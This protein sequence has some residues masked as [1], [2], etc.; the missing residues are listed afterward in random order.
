MQLREV[1][2][3]LVYRW[4]PTTA[5]RR[6][7]E[8]RQLAVRA[9]E[10]LPVH[11]RVRASLLALGFVEEFASQITGALMRQ[12]EFWAKHYDTTLTRA[13]H[14]VWNGYTKLFRDP[15][16]GF[17]V[18]M[19]LEST[20]QFKYDDP[21]NSWL[22]ITTMRQRFEP[23]ARSEP[24]YQRD[25]YLTTRCN[26]I[27][28]GYA[29]MARSWHNGSVIEMWH[30]PEVIIESLSIL[31]GLYVPRDIEIKI[32]WRLAFLAHKLSVPMSYIHI[33]QRGFGNKLLT[34]LLDLM[35]SGH[36]TREVMDAIFLDNT[37]IAKYTAEELR[38]S[39]DSWQRYAP[40][41]DFCQFVSGSS[42]VV[43]TTP[44]P[45]N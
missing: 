15:R 12:I 14:E 33:F 23:Y 5:W 40:T 10:W 39:I 45:P 21:E 36:A 6:L 17:R 30:D 31:E 24:P 13:H 44:V 4:I 37:L 11:D 32:A 38:L 16:N 28:Q 29:R 9:D 22:I 42:R 19:T 1:M 2:L 26:W 3:W 35:E 7:P 8:S 41:R 20:C 18:L 25:A 34:K 43:D 27:L